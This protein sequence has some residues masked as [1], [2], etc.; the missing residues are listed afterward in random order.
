MKYVQKYLFPTDLDT[1]AGLPCMHAVM[2]SLGAAAMAGTHGI[3]HMAGEGAVPSRVD[4]AAVDMG[5]F[6]LAPCLRVCAELSSRIKLGGE[7]NGSISTPRTSDR[8]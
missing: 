5:P 2:Q 7:K 8:T 1:S 3:Q 4:P 6:D